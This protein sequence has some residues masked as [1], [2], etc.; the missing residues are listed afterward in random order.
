MKRFF[1]GLVVSWAVGLALGAP[2]AQAGGPET[3]SMLVDGLVHDAVTRLSV[4][5]LSRTDREQV[6]H[7]L[8]VQYSDEQTLASQVLG[9]SWGSATP[10]ERSRFEERFG[11]YMVALCATMLK[12]VPPD[13]KFVVQG[14]E[15]Q[16]EKVVVHS[17]FVDTGGDST[18]V[19]WSV[20]H[21]GGDG[22]LFLTDVAS[23]GVS[24]VKTMSSDFRAVLFANGGHLSALVAAMNQKISHAAASD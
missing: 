12:D 1:F 19:D 16:G 5:G 9:R 17:V 3:P 20:G 10:D 6:V 22:H 2:A 23:D 24:M 11:A 21:A 7:T 8:I 15:A 4:K 18:P 14:E 13:I